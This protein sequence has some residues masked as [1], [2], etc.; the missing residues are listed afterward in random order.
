MQLQEIQI[1]NEVDIASLTNEA[2][3]NAVQTSDVR[4]ALAHHS[5]LNYL[6]Y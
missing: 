1:R 4:C 2:Q 5:E 6:T 3:R